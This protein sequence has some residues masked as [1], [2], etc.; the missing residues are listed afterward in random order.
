MLPKFLRCSQARKANFLFL[1]VLAKKSQCSACS[2]MLAKTIRHPS[3]SRKYGILFLVDIVETSKTVFNV[4]LSAAKLIFKQ[5][6]PP[7]WKS[8]SY[9][10]KKRLLCLTHK[11]YY[12][13][14]PDQVTTIIKKSPNLRNMRD[15]FKLT[16]DRPNSNVGKLSFKHRSAMAWNSLPQSVKSIEDHNSFKNKLRYL[17]SFIDR[18]SFNQSAIIYN[19][20][21]TNYVY[22]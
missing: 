7:S 5:R 13:L 3:Y 14:C 6:I 22:F 18:I 9:L 15:N 21:L 19:K 11:A 10:Y 2:R 16:L 1:L 20:D 17:S 4:H 8:I 12:G